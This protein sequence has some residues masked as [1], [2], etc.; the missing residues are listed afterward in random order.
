MDTIFRLSHNKDLLPFMVRTPSVHAS[1]PRMV[2]SPALITDKFILLNIVTLDFN[3]LQQGGVY[4]TKNGIHEFE[5]GKTSEIPFFI[6]DDLPSGKW[7]PD[8]R[9]ATPK[10]MSACLLDVTQLKDA[11]RE[12]KVTGALELLVQSLDEDDNPIVMIVTFK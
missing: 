12:K 11:Y 4:N 9:V 8:A 1:E 10:N 5:R 3:A 2:W 6:N 7:W